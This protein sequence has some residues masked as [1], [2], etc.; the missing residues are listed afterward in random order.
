MLS[1][2]GTGTPFHEVFIRANVQ[3]NIT[4][5]NSEAHLRLLRPGALE[6]CS[7]SRSYN[8]PLLDEELMTG[9]MFLLY[10]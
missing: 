9:G 1:Q 3:V 6:N 4:H 2:W 10:F 5:A 7:L 8:N